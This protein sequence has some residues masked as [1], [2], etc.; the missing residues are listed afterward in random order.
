MQK[1]RKTI[2][3]SV[4]STCVVVGILYLIIYVSIIA[5]YDFNKYIYM[6]TDDYDGVPIGI[7]SLVTEHLLGKGAAYFM[8]IIVIISIFGSAYA[9]ACGF[10]FIPYAAAKSGDFFKFFAH[11]STTKSG[12][13]D[14][15]VLLVF[16]LS[17]LWCFFSLDIVIDAMVTLLVLMQFMAQSFGLILYRYRIHKLKQTRP[18]DAEEEHSETWK[19]PG[20]PLPCIIQ[21]ILFG[22]IFFTSDS[23]ILYG[24][25]PIL[26]VAVGY[27]V[28]GSIAFKIFDRRRIN[29]IQS[30]L[31]ESAVDLSETFNKFTTKRQESGVTENACNE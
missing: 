2:P 4:V 10:G 5:S 8:T 11:E 14:Y 16:L 17:T 27:L 18:S 31:P 20:Y 7:I 1:P 22:F 3:I 29:S 19:V 26:E 12:L 15:S 6:Y 30:T 13:A 28:I 23:Y 25:Q 21:F 24:S 9:M